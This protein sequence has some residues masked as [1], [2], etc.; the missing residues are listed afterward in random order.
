LRAASR[1]S[2]ATVLALPVRSCLIDGELIAAGAHGE[3]DFL[4]LLHARHVPVCVYAFDLLGSMAATFAAS[5]LRSGSS[6]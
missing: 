4:A 5:P 3:P 1:P 2:P 6:A